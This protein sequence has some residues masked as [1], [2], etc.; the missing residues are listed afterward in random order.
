M[1]S[2]Y[3]TFNR[4]CIEALKFYAKVFNA[5]IMDLQYYG[6]MLPPDGSGS[7]PLADRELVLHARLVWRGSEIMFSDSPDRSTSGKNMSISITLNEAEFIQKTW[8]LLA[9]GAQE[10]YMELQPTFFA[11]AHG[12]LRDRFGINWM[13]TAMAE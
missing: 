12:S 3:L 11:T 5:E 4:N 2:H 10:I 13:L 9:T 8:N 7:L 1:F 6:D